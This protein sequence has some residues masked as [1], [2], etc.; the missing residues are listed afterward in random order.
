MELLTHASVASFAAVFCVFPLSFFFFFPYFS[1]LSKNLLRSSFF[2]FFCPPPFNLPFILSFL[3]FAKQ[4]SLAPQHIHRKR[5]KRAAVI[6][7]SPF[8]PSFTPLL[9]FKKEEKKHAKKKGESLMTKT[10]YCIMGR[11]AS[12]KSPCFLRCSGCLYAYDMLLY[13]CLDRRT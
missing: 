4:P 1:I 9:H 13:S 2:F 8:V 7:S 10:L 12:G 11:T 3:F 6:F 5:Q